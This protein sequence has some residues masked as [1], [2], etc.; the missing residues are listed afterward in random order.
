MGARWWGM[1]QSH[2]YYFE[3]ST[4][5]GLL[6]RAGLRTI[7]TGAGCRVFT[8]RYWA[9]QLGGYNRPIGMLARAL[10]VGPLGFCKLKVSFRD[11]LMVL[12]GKS[13]RTMV[14]FPASR[15]M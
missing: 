14:P 9:R 10:C 8:I 7:K 2:L 1:Q 15:A 3:R 13:S 11:H 6:D 4:L 12:A 5:I